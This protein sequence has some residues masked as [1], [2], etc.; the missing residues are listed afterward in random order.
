MRNLLYT[1][2]ISTA[3][4]AASYASATDGDLGATS[5][6]SFAISM[7]VLTNNAADISITGLEDIDFGIIA[8]GSTPTPITISSICVFISEGTKYSVELD[9]G[10]NSNRGEGTL[11]STDGGEYAY[12]F[13]YVG[14][15]G[16]RVSGTNTNSDFTGSVLEDCGQF[17]SASLTISP[18][19]A[20]LSTSV[21]GAIYSGTLDLTVIPD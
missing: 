9:G 8:L 11:T 15:V 7:T 1:A 13:E 2:V 20:N 16:T 3:F 6:G 19:L 5:T 17:A 18:S 10:L 4:C 12:D 14:P 21:P